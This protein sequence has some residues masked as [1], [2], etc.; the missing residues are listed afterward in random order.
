[1]IY[2]S[3]QGNILNGDYSGAE[4]E[5]ILN[6]DGTTTP[7]E[8]YW[9]SG[10]IP[11][12]NSTHIRYTANN[13]VLIS[14]YY[15]ENGDLVAPVGGG[16]MNI[17]MQKIPE[18]TSYMRLCLTSQVYRSDNVYI[19]LLSK[20]TPIY[21]E[22]LALETQLESEQRFYRTSLSGELTFLR[23]DY[24]DIIN[25]DFETQFEVLVIIDNEQI[26]SGR[27]FK[28]DCTINEYDRYIKVKP[29]AYDVYNNVLAGLEN[30]YDLVKLKP[31]IEALTITKRPLIQIYKRGDSVISCFLSGMSWEQDCTVITDG[32]ALINT[33]YFSYVSSFVEINVTGNGSVDA[34]GI[35]SAETGD[36]N[37]KYW[38]ADGEFYIDYLR[39]NTVIRW[40][41][42]D[43]NNNMLY[44]TDGIFDGSLFPTGE[45]VFNVNYETTGSFT[46]TGI[47][48]DIYARYILDVDTINGQSTHPIPESDIVDNNRNYRRA[49][50]YAI[51]TL[52]MS[53]E[54]SAEPTAWGKSS[55]GKYFVEP[56]NIYGDKFYPIGR[57][58]WNNISFWFSFS[59]FDWILEEAGRKKYV[60]KD[61]YE[62]SSCISV[63]LDQFSG[64][65][66]KNTTEY[67]EFL[68]GTNPISG[69]DFKLFISQKTN[70]INGEYQTPAQTAPITLQDIT[71][72]LRDVY[73]CYWFIEDNKFRIEHI[74][75]FRNGGSY[76]SS[77]IV[78]IDYT[79]LEN[80]R[81][82][83][84]WAFNTSEYTFDKIDLAERYEF[85]WMDDVEETFKGEPIEV[86]SNY[87]TAGKVEEI[88]VSNFTSDIDLM[89]LNPSAINS[90]GF[91]LF[92]A[93]DN[94][95]P[96]LDVN[97][98][99]VNYKI[100]NGY[101]AY[102]YI[103]PQFWAR[104]DMPARKLKV[105][106]E[107]F[108][109]NSI[110]RK[111]KQELKAP[112]PLNFNPMQLVKTYLGNG[113]V[114]KISLN[115][116][117]L[118]AEINLKYD[119]E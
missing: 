104:Y 47:A 45:L 83:K 18:G 23:N 109:P 111:K 73:K 119:T 116:S 58:A 107:Y 79:A 8:N 26:Y 80:K 54:F 37:P 5:H 1:M 51:D 21:K 86:L 12:G 70:L 61:T 87:V 112:L 49:I 65:Q 53:R 113:E 11:I 7:D 97:V 101:C 110:A 46:S 43:K 28:T 9:T 103:L 106:G 25:A 35:Y 22:D 68:Y 82:G 98:D 10:I 115:L 19:G 108:M 90:D 27:F 17:G 48:S 4:P 78:G 105:N 102:S 89:L 41:L 44:Q 15:K 34:A 57:T 24:D 72:M 42:R 100:Q 20:S 2:L 118:T 85:K 64:V 14:A 6:E 40:N 71:N 60:I 67:S 99:G 88:N 3:T 66:H 59:V 63:L 33:Y 36:L 75:W 76:T 117:D 91:V 56:I 55:N 69:T 13:V 50:G 96:F 114:E 74:E 52:T 32:N 30:E 95:I 84:K 77:G 94:E 31:K 81:N 29:E 62:L 16:I 93:V 39:I 92:G 38:R